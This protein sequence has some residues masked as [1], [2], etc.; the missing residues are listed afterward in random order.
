[1]SNRFQLFVLS[2]FILFLEVL[3]IRWIGTEVSIFAYLQ[4]A[5][6]VCC[7]LGLGMG[8]MAKESEYPLS[9]T[10]KYL[11]IFAL[12]LSLPVLREYMSILALTLSSFHDFVVWKQVLPQTLPKRLAMLG[13]GMMAT[14][15][16][17]S[18]VWRMMVPLGATLARLLESDDKP[19]HAYTVNI[20]GSLLGVWLFSGMAWFSL[21][22]AYWFLVL[23]ALAIPLAL[24][25]PS[26]GRRGYLLLAVVTF[27][28]LAGSYFDTGLETRWSPYQKLEIIPEPG[29]LPEEYRIVV[30]NT[31]Y[32]G[33]QNDAVEVV[34]GKFPELVDSRGLLSQYDVPGRLTPN[35]QEVLVVGAGSGN[36]VAGVLRTTKAHVTAVEIDP[37]ILQFGRRYHPEKPYDTDR[38]TP[39]VDDARSVFMSADKKFDL[40]VFGLLDS[41]STPALTTSRLDHYVYTLESLKSASSLLKPDGVLVLIFQPQ[42]YYVLERLARSLTEVFSQ[43]PIVFSAP[44]DELGWGGVVFVSG[45]QEKIAKGLADDPALA[46]F[47]EKNRV[48]EA[49]YV[50]TTVRPT[51]DNWPYLYLERPSIPVLFIALAII[52]VMLW[53]QSSRHV[54]KG[55]SFKEMLG[56]EGAF[57]AAMGA[58]F[59]LFQVFGVNQAAILFGS[60]WIVNSIVISAIL[61]MIMVANFVQ[62]R[63]GLYRARS[64]ILGLLVLCLVIIYSLNFSELIHLSGMSKAA[65]VLMVFGGPMFLSGICFAA[66]FDR[67]KLRSQALAAN[68]FG[69]LIGGALQLSTFALG[70]KSLILLSMVAYLLAL[71]CS[72][73]APR[74]RQTRTS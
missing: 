54:L 13:A 27:L 55:I 52:L 45:N 24:K 65:V 1:M 17:A 42:R 3:L 30:N 46:A 48:D 47:I 58:G 9:D 4:N 70:I 14:F 57:F 39:I 73:R 25:T 33:I 56:R 69:A 59:S 34:K 15:I 26:F 49:T 43:K 32:Q 62:Q 37:V 50:N 19:I 35:A 61:V 2:V 66:T 22:P 74:Q 68:L 28:P 29:P 10:F 71:L 21:A 40:I 20:F 7:F 23:G 31:G 18:F 6:L 12:L 36:D 67:T 41:H 64:T 53:L 5:I 60:S 72:T 16:L 63:F 44:S 51:T 38:V 11:G 8:C